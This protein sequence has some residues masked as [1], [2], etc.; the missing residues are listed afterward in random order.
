MTE[1]LVLVDG[2]RS[3]S[4]RNSYQLV[5][6]MALDGTW[7]EERHPSAGPLIG[8]VAWMHSPEHNIKD[9]EN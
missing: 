7:W 8:V 1:V 6:Y 2:H 5:A 3:P 9:W 4:W